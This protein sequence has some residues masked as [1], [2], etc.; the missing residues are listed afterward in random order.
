MTA[1]G[2][3]GFWSY[4]HPDDSAEHGRIIGV[5]HRLR[6]EVRLLTGQELQLF[7]DRDDLAWGD[8]WRESI[9]EALAGIT[10]FIPIVTPRYF[11]SEECRRELLTFAR[12]ARSAGVGELLLPIL[13][14]DVPGLDTAADDE[15]FAAVASVQWEDWREL[16]L[17]DPD[18]PAHRQGVHRLARRLVRIAEDVALKPVVSEEAD[19]DPAKRLAE[20]NDMIAAHAGL[21]SEQH[22]SGD[23]APP[24]I[25][26]VLAEAEEALPRWTQTVEEMGE[27]LQTIG[28]LAEEA[29]AQVQRNDA[30]GKGFAGRLAAARRLST[31]LEVPANR[32]LSLGSSYASDLMAVDAGFLTLIDLLR[33]ELESEADKQ[34]AKEF[35]STIREMYQTSSETVA[36]LRE[37]LTGTETVAGFSRELRPQIRKIQDAVRRIVDGLAVMAEWVARLDAAGLGVN[38]A[39]SIA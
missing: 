18:S 4:A 8:R 38:G 14:V 28:R 11:Q 17:E 21:V 13:Y 10:F 12:R 35:A 3:A 37:L 6:E 19:E 26:D 1:A 7:L 39:N 16:R 25:L 33:E 2:A 27:L 29:T 36:S 22:D 24:G 20:A 32:L 23:G 15:A 9:D 34:A 5:A 31:E 30:A